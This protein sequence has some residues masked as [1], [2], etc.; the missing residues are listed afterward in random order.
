MT[1]TLIALAMVTGGACADAYATAMAEASDDDLSYTA[2]SAEKV[3]A[4]ENGWLIMYRTDEEMKP[5]AVIGVAPLRAGE[6]KEIAPVLQD[7]VE[8]DDMVM[9][10]VQPEDS[11][12]KQTVFDVKP[13]EVQPNKPKG[14][15]VMKVVNTE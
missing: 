15:L 10:I 14:A 5:G 7:E 11:D 8:E 2:V 12:A 13:E 9:M 3:I 6:A 1:S 4:D